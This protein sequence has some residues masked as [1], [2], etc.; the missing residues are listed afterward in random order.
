MRKIRSNIA[1]SLVLGLAALAQAAE[2]ATTIDA[3]R[4]HILVRAPKAGLFSAF[5]HDH[6]VRAPILRGKIVESEPG[7][8]Q[9]EIDARAMTV[10]D[11]Q[12]SPEKRAEVQTTMRGPKVLD[13]GRFPAISFVSTQVE[14][15][16]SDHW[17]VAGDLTLHGITRPVTAEVERRNGGY[18]GRAKFRQTEF[19]IKPISLAGGTI[20]VKDEVKIEFEVFTTPVT[21]PAR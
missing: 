6:E 19:G 20:K 2:P 21:S 15:R 9:L 10:L 18:F 8:V 13:S 17:M 12:L 16:G 4:S 11:P 5:G 7:S 3:R 1:F 14:P